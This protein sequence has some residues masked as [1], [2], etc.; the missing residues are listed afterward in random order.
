MKSR[1]IAKAILEDRQNR[2]ISAPR[3]KAPADDFDPFAATRWRIIVDGQDRRGRSGPG[4]LPKTAMRRG[5]AGWFIDCRC[6]GEEFESK[7]WAFCS[8]CMERPVEELRARRKAVEA[9]S[10]LSGTSPLHRS[11][12]ILGPPHAK[13][14]PKSFKN[15]HPF[16]ALR[17]GLQIWSAR[18]VAV[19]D[20]CRPIWSGPLSRP[21]HLA[22]CSAMPGGAS[23]RRSVPHDPRSTRPPSVPG[24]RRRPLSAPRSG[25]PRRSG[26]AG[27]TSRNENASRNENGWR[28]RLHR[29]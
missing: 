5:P 6:C 28:E 20:Y 9:A 19:G 18:E 8:P 21:R 2:K 15:F 13:I 27:S 16:S 10:R 23:R 17:T 22:F 4:Y 14:A 24:S 3:S 1:T 26:G 29:R 12:K 25:P 7:G 11:H